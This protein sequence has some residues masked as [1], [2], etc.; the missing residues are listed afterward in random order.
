ML[1]IENNPK[2][3]K[4][5][6]TEI[7]E[8]KNIVA[9]VIAKSN[10][11]QSQILS[12]QV[13]FASAEAFDEWFSELSGID[14]KLS[15]VSPDATIRYLN[16]SIHTMKS[17]MF[18]YFYGHPNAAHFNEISATR[19]ICMLFPD[20]YS[21]MIDEDCSYL[22]ISTPDGVSL[23]TC[24]RDHTTFDFS[25]VNKDVSKLKKLEL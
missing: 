19:V 11:R 4:R 14:K 9:D 3:F 21:L 16:R 5:T 17:D 13:R 7:D 18:I 25:K 15:E 6:K 23:F 10:I 22:Y 12:K 20:E 2:G 1:E 24:D 8:I